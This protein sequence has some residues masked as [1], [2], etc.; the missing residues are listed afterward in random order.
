ME[1]TRRSVLACSTVALA[2]AS[3]AWQ[4]K[5]AE[6]LHEATPSALRWLRQLGCQHA[7]FQPSARLEKQD[8]IGGGKPYWN[9]E[10]VLRVKRACDE[11]GLSLESMMLPI[12]F[13]RQALLGGPG[14]DREI[15]NVCRTLRAVADAGV[16][17]MEWRFWPDF[18]F[19]ERVGYYNVS[20]RGG[21]GLRGFDYDRI[22]DAPPFEEIGRVSESEMWT[23]FLYFARPLIETAEKAGVRLSMH[24]ND[25]P[26][27]VMRGVA[28][29]FHHTDG[30]RR[31]LK[32]IPSPASGITFCQGTIT[33]MGVDVLEEIRYFG[34]LGKI[35]LVHLRAVRG[36]VPRYTEVFIDEGDLDM[37]QAVRTYKE[38]G[39]TGPIVSDHT[40]RV[41]GDTPW[42][43]TGR[44]FS[45]GY[46]R[47][48]IQ[49]ADRM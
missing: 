10:D 45:L 18:F 32:E 31:F 34:R 29:I 36:T 17:M 7:V 19:D 48:M 14:R 15:E 49:A 9:A 20:G 8:R 22:R 38:V 5:L 21:A 47:A 40:P 12:D 25:P 42:G 39:Y 24:P 6:N 26:V 41:E 2:H 1:V 37:L 23:R 44:A 13:Y 27:P 30:L 46:I 11:A 33:E 35:H 3:S 16:P 43:H 4:P 28:R